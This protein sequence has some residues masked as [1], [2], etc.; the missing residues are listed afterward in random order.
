MQLNL[1]DTY[2]RFSILIFFFHK[3]NSVVKWIGN[4]ACNFFAGLTARAAKRLARIS[5]AH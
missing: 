4:I 2:P 1:R 5:R 3:Q